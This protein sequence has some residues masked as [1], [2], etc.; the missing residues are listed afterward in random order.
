ME[1]WSDILHGV[2]P[3]SAHTF[4]WSHDSLILTIPSAGIKKSRSAFTYRLVYPNGQ[5]K[6]LGNDRQ[7][8]ELAVEFEDERFELTNGWRNDGKGLVLTPSALDSTV[9]KLTDRS[10]WAIW[11]FTAER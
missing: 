6:W 1:M 5:I 11:S 8:G 10:E 9:L 7:N 3:W 4:R 2:G